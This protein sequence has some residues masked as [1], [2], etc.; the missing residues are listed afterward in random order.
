M[1]VGWPGAQTPEQ[2]QPQ[3]LGLQQALPRLPSGLKGKSSEPLPV[4][5]TSK[6]AFPV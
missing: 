3:L 5:D 4:P 2:P 6:G 1:A